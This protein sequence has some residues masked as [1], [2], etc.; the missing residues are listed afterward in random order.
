MSGARRILVIKLGALG[1]FIQALG[2]MAAIRRH[3]PDAFIALLT[4][5]PYVNFG[6]EC[7]YFDQIITD[8]RPRGL[9]VKGWLALRRKLNAG[10]FDRVYDLQNNDRT[11][12]YLRL[13]SPRPEWVGAARG[14]SH[15][16][17]S[18]QRT[19][20]HAFDGHVQT[21]KLAGIENI[22]IDDLSWLKG[23]AA[24]LVPPA[25]YIL[26]VPGSAPNRPEKRWPAAHYGTL[27]RI[28]HGWGFNPVILG[29]IGEE[30]LAAAIRDIFPG[31]LDLTGKTALADIALLA[32]Q[33]AAAIGNDTGPMH[34]IAATGCPCTVLFSRH[35]DPKRHAPLGAKVSAIQAGD[36]AAL[37]PDELA[38]KLHMRDFRKTGQAPSGR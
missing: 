7:G 23:S 37:R 34:L 1:D 15:R 31:A 4:T 6:R 20:G 16:N 35:S 36:L 27:A 26:L 14:A 2:P 8:H 25:P 11:S 33:A 18:P 17:D 19:A 10:R 24:H 3:H 12:L 28:L 30:P 29:T 9:N 13:F 5:E 38:A 22:A 32:R 21:L